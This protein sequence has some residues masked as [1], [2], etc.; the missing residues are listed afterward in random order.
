MPHAIRKCVGNLQVLTYSNRFFVRLLDVIQRQTLLD[1]K[2]SVIDIAIQ[3]L[4]TKLAS[5]IPKC[6]EAYSKSG[7]TAGVCV[8][9]S[10]LDFALQQ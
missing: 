5:S 7:S 1:V 2:I 4:Q 9:S 8:T 10:K 6:S 3:V